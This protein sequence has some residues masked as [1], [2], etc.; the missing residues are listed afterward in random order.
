MQE[1]DMCISSVKTINKIK[2]RKGMKHNDKH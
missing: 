1:D 2:N